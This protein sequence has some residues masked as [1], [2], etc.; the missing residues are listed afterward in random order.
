MNRNLPSRKEKAKGPWHP[1]QKIGHE[2][3]KS[4]ERKCVSLTRQVAQAVRASKVQV[5]EVRNKRKDFMGKGES[6]GW[7]GQAGHTSILVAGQHELT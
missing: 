2:P 4:H 7:E 3:R 6:R 1:R 5:A